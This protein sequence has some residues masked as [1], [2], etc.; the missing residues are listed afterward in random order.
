[1]VNYNYK[2]KDSEFY[3]SEVVILSREENDN[4][5]FKLDNDEKR[6][7][8]RLNAG[9]IR[10]LSPFVKNL[11]YDYGTSCYFITDSLGGN[12]INLNFFINENGEVMGIGY[13]ND[14]NQIIDVKI[15]SEFDKYPFET[16]DDFKE[17]LETRITM[18]KDKIAEQNK[19]NAITTVNY[20]KRKLGK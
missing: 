7:L 15:S 10:R 5:I 3:E 17:F 11:E 18:E 14:N 2:L 16:Y 1:M 6:A 13:T 12:I 8:G 19:L 4:V 20:A 9:K